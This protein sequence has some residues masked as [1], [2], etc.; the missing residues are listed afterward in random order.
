[1]WVVSRPRIADLVGGLIMKTDLTQAELLEK[2]K[3]QNGRVRALL[4]FMGL[5]AAIMY[6]LTL[7]HV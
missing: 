1:M 4:V 7:G 2:Q 3:R 6:G 5:L